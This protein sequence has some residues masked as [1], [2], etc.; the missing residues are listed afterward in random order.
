MAVVKMSKVRLLG[1]I[2]NREAILDA[3]HKT[4][5]V[6]LKEPEELTETFNLPETSKIE[7]L[8]EK[9]DRIRNAIDFV[10]ENVEK[11]KDKSAYSEET[12]ESFGNFFVSY[13]EFSCVGE[14]EQEVFD[15]VGV[16]ENFQKLL[17]DSRAQKIKLNNLRSQLFP[18][19]VVKDK[20]SIYQDTDK[21]K[22]LLGTIKHENIIQLT[23]FLN[24]YP[25]TQL[26]IEKD[27][28]L[29]VI[30]VVSFKDESVAVVQ[31]LNELGFV[32]CPFTFDI[33]VNEK[34]L[35]IDNDILQLE[36]FDI[37]IGESVRAIAKNLRDMKIFADYLKFCIEKYKESENFRCTASTFVLEGYLP[38]ESIE[39]VINSV[40]AVTSAIF[41][42][43]SEPLENETPPTL[44]KNNSVLKQTEFITDLYSVPNYREFD[45]SKVVFFFF[46]IFMGVI[47][48]D[49]GYGFLMILLGLF[50]ARRIKIDSGARRLWYIIA[51]G[52][53]FTI[54]FGIL[55]NSV[56]GFAIQFMPTILPS[57]IP[58][59]S[60]ST[61]GMMIILLGC[62]GLGV[63]QIA[64]GYF[65]KALNSFRQ[66]DVLSGVFDGLIWVLFFIGFIFAA[67]NFLVAYLMPNLVMPSWLFNFFN[68]MQMPGIIMV[69][70]S[71]FVAAVTAG[72]KEK[73]FGKFTKGFGAVYGLIN[74]MSDILSYARLFG[75]MLSGMIVAQTFNDL[76]LGIISGGGVGYLFGA[77]VMVLGHTFNI[78]MGVLGAYI[79]DSRLQYIE[80]FSKFYTGEGEKFTPLGSQFEYIYLTK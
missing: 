11:F 59:D 6:E 48:A 47:M 22:V 61:E 9:Y 34:I 4:G 5:A 55:F 39:A 41:I 14:K 76:G 52:G 35:E 72:R 17:L 73:G 31:K 25:L 58:D 42:E 69:V 60:G 28:S 30:S 70:G 57:P 63:I 2:H 38:E 66:G 26:T 20:L 23:S 50:L 13:K 15:T 8:T 37:E 64:T 45:P 62:L 67:F 21:T 33:T 32:A 3:L 75:L 71:V 56:F 12:V 74:I 79:H 1:L 77:L 24:N 54:I 46:M 51:I 44:L 78:A 80:F 29:S 49:V 40:K 65:C 18:F 68:A 7:E 53:I 27:D 16:V 10:M 19:V 43:F 36:K